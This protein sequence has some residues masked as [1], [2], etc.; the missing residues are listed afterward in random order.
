MCNEHSQHPLLYHLNL[1]F[2]SY[3]WLDKVFPEEIRHEPKSSY[4]DHYKKIMNQPDD[5]T[6]HNESDD[7]RPESESDDNNKPESDT[8]F[9]N[10][11]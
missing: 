11:S 1:T 8:Y 2:R 10:Q 9:M 5:D 3:D 6:Y 7:G 4:F